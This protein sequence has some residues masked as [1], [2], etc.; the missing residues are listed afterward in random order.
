M[1]TATITEGEQTMATQSI[2][3]IRQQAMDEFLHGDKKKAWEL[4]QRATLAEAIEKAC[5]S[6]EPRTQ[7]R[8]K[9]LAA[10]KWV[11]RDQFGDYA[12]LGPDAVGPNAVKMVQDKA[13]AAVFDGRD[14]E[15]RKVA[16]YNAI[17]GLNFH[18]EMV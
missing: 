17:T 7:E 4:N 1:K 2:N 5:A 15:E 18:V 13:Q 14:N 3:P 6:T 16:F 9:A 8:M 12:A 11:L 10:V